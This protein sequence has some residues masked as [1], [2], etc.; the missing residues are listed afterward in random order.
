MK[1]IVSYVDNLKRL[2]IYAVLK[3]LWQ[4]RRYISTQ[5][6]PRFNI[7]G[8]MILSLDINK[9]VIHLSSRDAPQI[10][11]EQ[12]PSNTANMAIK[13]VIVIKTI[14]IFVKRVK[15]QRGQSD[16]WL[17]KPVFGIFA[18]KRNF[19]IYKQISNQLLSIL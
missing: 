3:W 17:K 2:R 12:I 6:P 14:I 16:M 9:P 19:Q 10:K 8:L 18:E 15:C 5:G 7:L 11:R 1:I 13:S 4:T